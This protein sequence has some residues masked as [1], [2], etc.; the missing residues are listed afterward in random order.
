L[1]TGAAQLNANC[2]IFEFA[3]S[4]AKAVGGPGTVAAIIGKSEVSLL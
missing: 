4:L 3:S 1:L 2:V